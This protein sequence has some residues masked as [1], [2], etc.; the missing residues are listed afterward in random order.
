MLTMDQEQYKAEQRDRRTKMGVACVYAAVLPALRERA[1]ELGYALGLHGS[2]V[3][4]MDLIAAPWVA[5]AVSSDELAEALQ[6]VLGG[7]VGP[8]SGKVLTWAELQKCSKPHGRTAYTLRWGGDE[9]LFVDL[10]VMPRL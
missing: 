8:E 3:R 6:A 1:R 2:L 4:D 10:S 5:E 7:W 9:L